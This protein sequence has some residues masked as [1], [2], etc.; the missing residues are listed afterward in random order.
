VSVKAGDRLLGE[1][2]HDRAVI[3]TTRF[4]S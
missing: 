3:D 1:G 2:T 4:A